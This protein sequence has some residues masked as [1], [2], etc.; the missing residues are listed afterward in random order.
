MEKEVK[1]KDVKNFILSLILIMS[2]NCYSQ[3]NQHI[4]QLNN[5]IKDTHLRF[6]LSFLVE[7][8]YY[9]EI[10]INYIYK[11]YLDANQAFF[12]VNNIGTQKY[13]IYSY[14]F[15]SGEAHAAEFIMLINNKSDDILVLGYGDFDI[16]KSKLGAFLNN[17]IPNTIDR[18]E[19]SSVLLKKLEQIYPEH[20]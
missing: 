15:F 14:H 10:G 4:N 19:V 18:D 8:S 11:H 20:R 9:D 12:I 3:N 7:N 13:G 2:F 5:N 6:M 17:N 16:N 1:R